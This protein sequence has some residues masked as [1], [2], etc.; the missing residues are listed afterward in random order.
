MFSH[1]FNIGA[2]RFSCLFWGMRQNVIKICPML[3]QST[4][5]DLMWLFQYL[6]RIIALSQQLIHW[7]HNNNNKKKAPQCHKRQ[8]F[9]ILWHCFFPVTIANICFVSLY[10]PFFSSRSLIFCLFILHWIVCCFQKI[11]L[12]YLDNLIMYNKKTATC[13]LFCLF[14]SFFE[15]FAYKCS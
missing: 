4:T 2:F 10:F 5:H 8:V 12:F 14:F 7:R 11:M 13:C 6:N 3:R 15:S 1:C 9:C